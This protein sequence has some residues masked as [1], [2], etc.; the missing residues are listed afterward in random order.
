VTGSILLLAP[1]RGLGGGIE[2]YVSTIE[3][4]FAANSIPY[5]R[6]DLR[7]PGVPAGT[8]QRIGFVR[9]VRQA[10]RS[11][12]GP[13]RLVLAH[14][15]LL[16]VVHAVSRFPNFAAATVIV[17]GNEVWSGNRARGGRTMR[18]PDVRVVAASNFTAGAVAHLCRPSVL[19]PGVPAPWYDTLVRA[20]AR[21]RPGAKRQL[22][23][24]TTFRL[25]SWR[26]KGLG[27]LLIAVSR[28]GIDELRL[29]VCG[30]GPVP[31]DLR[32]EVAAYPWCRLMPDLSD[33]DLAGQLAGADL[34]VLCTR[35]RAGAGACGEGFGLVLL[36]AQLAGTPVIAPAHGGSS[37]AFLPGVTGVAPVDETPS[38]LCAVL[39]PLLA[40]AGR[41]AEMGR[42][43]AAWSRAR[44]EPAT[45]SRQIVRAL[46]GEEPL[47]PA[48][49]ADNQGIAVGG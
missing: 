20:G 39:A 28:L 37:D 17:H 31:D 18:R 13:A 19:H 24:V 44:F 12:P 5:R 10:V 43:A 27:T 4:A 16:P 25:S 34:F 45:Y 15:N 30:S 8:R 22:H 29:T 7:R 36:E 48:G 46:L 9:E 21:E 6:L 11:G 49:P 33:H 42:A 1:S 47:A 23:L 41:R 35:T 3:V 14:R 26:D 40:D 38:A 2:R 32:A